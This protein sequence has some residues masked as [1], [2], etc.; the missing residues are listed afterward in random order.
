MRTEAGYAILVRYGVTPFEGDG[1]VRHSCKV[2]RQDNDASRHQLSNPQ[3]HQG[4]AR[5]R[6]ELPPLAS[7]LDILLKSLASS[8]DVTFARESPKLVAAL[9]TGL[10]VL[11][12]SP[13]GV[14][15]PSSGIT[16]ILELFYVPDTLH[17]LRA[18][19]FELHLMGHDSVGGSW[20]M[21][22]ALHIFDGSEPSERLRD[23]L[24][25]AHITPMNKSLH[26]VAAEMVRIGKPRVE[27]MF[28]T[29]PTTWPAES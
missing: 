1:H 29:L 21:A 12:T 26:L 14:I 23:V 3:S 24:P 17:R 9:M 20:T 25:F 7:G 22:R 13:S 18:C 11:A 2:L 15:P 4:S 6:I 19:S 27:A 28:K 10:T 8:I 5:T 16:V